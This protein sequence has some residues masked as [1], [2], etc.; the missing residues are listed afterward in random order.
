MLMERAPNSNKIYE[1]KLIQA[2]KETKLHEKIDVTI[3]EGFAPV[4]MITIGEN[5]IVMEKESA[6][7]L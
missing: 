6:K 1:Y 7:I 3:A 2:R 5:I 4:T